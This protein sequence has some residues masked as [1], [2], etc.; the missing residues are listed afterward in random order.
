M[1]LQLSE[2]SAA[3]AAAADRGEAD[4]SQGELDTITLEME[5]K[6][7]EVNVCVSDLAKLSSVDEGTL[8]LDSKLKAAL[9]DWELLAAW[10]NPVMHG[11]DFQEEELQALVEA[12]WTRHSREYGGDSKSWY[13]HYALRHMAAFS[14]HLQHVYPEF[15]LS[16]FSTQT[17]EAN[18]NVG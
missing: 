17:S 6:Q 11:A 4:L 1:Q 15:S 10:L 5:A 3:V 8:S 9:D 14:T 2:A 7:H 16:S 18:N 13:V 12:W